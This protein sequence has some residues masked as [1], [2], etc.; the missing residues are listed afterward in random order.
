MIAVRRTLT[1]LLLEVTNKEIAQVAQETLK[2]YK[3][4]GTKLYAHID[5]IKHLIAA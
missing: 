1:E 5:F 4:K 2:S 3:T